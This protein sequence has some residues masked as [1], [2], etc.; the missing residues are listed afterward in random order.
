M[1]DRIPSLGA[2]R[3]GP[4]ILILLKLGDAFEVWHHLLCYK[5]GASISKKQ[6]HLAAWKL[7]NSHYSLWGSYGIIQQ[8]NTHTQKSGFLKNPRSEYHISI[9]IWE[10]PVLE[11]P[12]IFPVQYTQTWK[13]LTF[14]HPLTAI[15]KVVAMYSVGTTTTNNTW[16]LLSYTFQNNVLYAIVPLNL[17]IWENNGYLCV[18][19]ALILKIIVNHILAATFFL[20]LQL[21]LSSQNKR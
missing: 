19:L 5:F 1:V 17:I 15:K 16:L 4:P 7:P 18:C 8:K 14:S 3:S 10:I 9:R 11:N 6:A 13:L 21:P 20:I 2:Y 12:N